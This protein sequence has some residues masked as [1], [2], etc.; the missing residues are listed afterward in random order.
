MTRELAMRFAA[1]YGRR[2]QPGLADVWTAW[3]RRLP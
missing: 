3:A 2:G 1:W